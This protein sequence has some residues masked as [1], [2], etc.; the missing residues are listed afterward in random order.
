MQIDSKNITNYRFSMKGRMNTIQ[1]LNENS[2][3]S[4]HQSKNN[5]SL[6]KINKEYRENF[7]EKKIRLGESNSNINQSSE[8]FIFLKLDDLQICECLIPFEF[9]DFSNF[10]FKNLKNTNLEDILKM[11]DEGKLYFDKT[12]NQQAKTFDGFT[13]KFFPILKLIGKKF[14]ISIPFKFSNMM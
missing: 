1:N 2:H 7:I 4:Y 8:E 3:Y 14:N 13:F 5:S 6:F 10:N 11:I 12:K 9:S